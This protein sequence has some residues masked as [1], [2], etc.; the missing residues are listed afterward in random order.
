MADRDDVGPS[1]L[2]ICGNVVEMR[3]GPDGDE[4]LCETCCMIIID[5]RWNDLEYIPIRPHP[6]GAMATEAADGD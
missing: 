3:R 2:C 6:G 1:F 4:G 5:H